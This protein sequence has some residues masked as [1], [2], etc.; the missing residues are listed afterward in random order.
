M[1]IVP[2]RNMVKRNRSDISALVRRGYQFGKKIGKGSYGNVV[3][4]KYQDPNSEDSI[5]L[6]CK[7]VNKD[8]APKDFLDKF[9][10]REIKVLTKITH[11]HIIKIHSILQS[12]ATVFIFMRFAENGDLLDFIKKSG[13]IPEPQANLWFYQMTSAIRY[14]HNM[15]LA[16]RDLKCENILISKHMN[17]KLADFGFARSCVEEETSMKILSNTYC[18]SAAYAAPEIV[19]GTPYD[20]LKADVWSLGVILFI[21][22]NA[23]MP[24][25]DNNLTKLICDQK[26]R[27]YHIRDSIA[28]K[29][30]IDCMTVLQ[31]LLE[32]S[33]KL[34]VPIT[35]VYSMKW[36]RKHVEKNPESDC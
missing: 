9:F 1:S 7:Y 2:S 24:F 17:T 19:S 23:V 22:L 4:A 29:L 35:K 32:P 6:A 21:M 31:N 20:P 15:N 28:S 36:L 26:A 16:H 18:G 33:A 27:R 11:P 34:R 30:S 25:D 5:D 14:L 8:K 3:T 13:P 10:P 12:G